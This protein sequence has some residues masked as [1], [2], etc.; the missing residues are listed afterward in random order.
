[1]GPSV[2]LQGGV[3]SHRPPCLPSCAGRVSWWQDQPLLQGATTSVWRCSLLEL[4]RLLRPAG[5]ERGSQEALD[6]VAQLPSPEP[7]ADPESEM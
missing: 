4:L 3:A 5:K 1:M 6:P 2:C 7:L